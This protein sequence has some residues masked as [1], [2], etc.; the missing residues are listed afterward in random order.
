[1]PYLKEEFPDTLWND[2]LMSDLFLG[3]VIGVVSFFI[4][5]NFTP[6]FI[7]DY[8]RKLRINYNVS[9]DS[10]LPRKILIIYLI[11]IFSFLIQ[12]Y[13]GFYTS[14]AGEGTNYDTKF[15]VLFSNTA[16]YVWYG[17]IAGFLWITSKQRVRSRF[18]NFLFWGM[19]FFSL[20]MGIFFLA[21]KT[22]LI[23]PILFF[24]LAININKVKI[25]MPVMIS[26]VIVVIFFTFL[27]IPQ[28]RDNFKKTFT[29]GNV[30]IE[31]YITVGENTLKDVSRTTPD[32]YYVGSSIIHRFSGLDITSVVFKN[33][34]NRY[35]YFYFEQLTSIFYSLIPRFI[36]PQKPT[37]DKADYFDFEIQGMIYGGSAAP[38]PLGEG[39]LNLGYVGIFLL[40]GLWGFTQSILYNG[41]FLPRKDNFIIQIIYI[42]IMLALIG[43][44]AWIIIY[45]ASILQ[46]IVFLIPIVLILRS[47]KM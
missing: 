39:F 11:G 25:K 3:L 5:F 24:M 8:F 27:F 10:K 23:Y 22:Y 6:K 36:Y 7:L 20:L 40:F 47:K 13:I 9:L 26:M 4:A 29:T 16:E 1:M 30:K 37:Q 14:F 41:I 38:T 42:V 18:G 2:T 32:I 33:V 45:I 44:G 19:L 12:V 21:S 17:L 28:Y 43:F 46:V 15:N 34:P 31:E 35:D